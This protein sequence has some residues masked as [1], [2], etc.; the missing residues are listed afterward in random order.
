MEEEIKYVR[1]HDLINGGAQRMEVICYLLPAVRWEGPLL[2]RL[3]ESQRPVQD[4]HLSS[5]SGG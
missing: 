3:W 1:D 4:G 2:R 5:P